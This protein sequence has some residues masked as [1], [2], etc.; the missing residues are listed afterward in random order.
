[1]H[2]PCVASSLL[3][4]AVLFRRCERIMKMGFPARKTPSMVGYNRCLLERNLF[5][6]KETHNSFT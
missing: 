2:A 3:I 4:Q 6:A 1:M 5:P